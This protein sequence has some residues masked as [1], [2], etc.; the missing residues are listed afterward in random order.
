MVLNVHRKVYSAAYKLEVP[1]LLVRPRLYR[2]SYIIK[3]ITSYRAAAVAAWACGTLDDEQAIQKL[4]NWREVFSPVGCY[5]ELNRTL[6]NL[7]GSVSADMLCTLNTM[8]LLRPITN[9]LELITVLCAG[10]QP[11]GRCR[12]FAFATADQIKE[13]MKRISAHMQKKLSPRRTN[14]IRQAVD[15]LLDYPDDHRGNIVGLANKAIRWHRDCWREQAEEATRHLSDNML[16]AVPPI[17]LP[18]V[19]GIRFL[20][21]LGDLRNESNAMQHCIRHYAKRAGDGACYL[22][23][24]EHEGD[25]ASV[26]V[27]PFGFVVQSQGPSNSQNRATEWGRNVLDTWAAAMR[28]M[29][30]VAGR[31]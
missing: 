16:T 26:E 14:D 22:F 2:E 27:S 13:A 11:P 15:F 18:Q 19:E 10:P 1:L 20:A 31:Y 28:H 4:T 23:H 30:E 6:M 12:V 8:L 3:D 9:R 25:H 24:V 17:P 5:R 7:P 21:S 29:T